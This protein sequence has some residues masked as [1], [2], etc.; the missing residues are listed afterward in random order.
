MA[1]GSNPSS[2]GSNDRRGA[3]QPDGR[4]AHCPLSVQIA[5]CIVIASCG[6]R[7]GLRVAC[8]V[9]LQPAL[10]R[11]VLVVDNSGSMAESLPDGRQ[12]RMAVIDAVRAALP[13]VDTYVLSGLMV[14]GLRV[15]RSREFE[16]RSPTSLDVP[17]R[18]TN[19]G[20]IS[21]SLDTP[22]G[23]SDMQGFGALHVAADALSNA[24]P[25]DGEPFIVFITD[26]GAVCNP[27]IPPSECLC[28]AG[29]ADRCYFDGRSLGCIDTRRVAA[30]LSDLHSHG[31]DTLLV[32]FT[33]N[34]PRDEPLRA[35][36]DAM[37]LA[38]GRPAPPGGPRYYD[39]A[40]PEQIARVFESVFGEAAFCRL[41]AESVPRNVPV[42]HWRLTA[43]D[44][45]TLPYDATG[46]EGW[47]WRDPT[48]LTISVHGEACR[49]LIATRPT[50]SLHTAEAECSE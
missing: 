28:L 32:G 37:A 12:K 41:H 50:L 16:C 11:V 43:G 26:G 21:T 18:R 3:E 40:Q 30:Y 42:G 44:G 47:T 48:R 17:P 7:T 19:A 49:Q 35:E 29:T 23:S 13:G 1:L 22:F 5:L 46:R 9:A 33:P 10:P 27:S 14:T 24:G 31:I 39:G 15:G 6:A 34:I 45:G 38:G 25:A 4:V 36:L 20:S 8:A 2:C